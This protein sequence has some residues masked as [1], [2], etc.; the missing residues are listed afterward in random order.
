MKKILTIIIF[1]ACM[2]C[3][4]QHITQ[5]QKDNREWYSGIELKQFYGKEKTKEIKTNCMNQDLVRFNM[6]RDLFEYNL[7]KVEL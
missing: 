4:T 7:I 5:A 2:S 1:I 6:K 3:S